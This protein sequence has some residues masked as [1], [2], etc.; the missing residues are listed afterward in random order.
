MILSTHEVIK[1]VRNRIE[2]ERKSIVTNIEVNIDCDSDEVNAVTVDFHEIRFKDKRTIIT[3]RL[4]NGDK[5][6]I[7]NYDIFDIIENAYPN[8]SIKIEYYWRGM[9]EYD[10]PTDGYLRIIVTLGDDKT[11]YSIEALDFLIDLAL[12]TKDKEWF[13]EL[14]TKRNEIEQTKNVTIK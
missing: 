4:D 5:V 3:M 2:T 14:V 10:T 12:Q 8:K 11:Y 1:I 6:P 7:S 9:Y 13:D